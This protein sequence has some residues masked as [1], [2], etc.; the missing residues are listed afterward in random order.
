VESNLLTACD[1]RLLV[2]GTLNEVCAN[3]V[4]GCTTGIATGEES[5]DQSLFAG[6]DLANALDATDGRTN[7]WTDSAS[8]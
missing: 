1:F 2:E 4:V 8:L 5:G 3:T 6:N 7:A